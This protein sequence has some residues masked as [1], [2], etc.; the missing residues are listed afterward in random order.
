MIISSSARVQPYPLRLDLVNG[1]LATY[2]VPKTLCEVAKRVARAVLIPF[3][4]I[5]DLA[6]NSVR[7]VGNFCHN[8][9]CCKKKAAPLPPDVLIKALNNLPPPKTLPPCTAEQEALIEELITIM[10]E[11]PPSNFYAV[12]YL[13]GRKDRL[14][15]IGKGI[16][17]VYPLTLLCL[18]SATPQRKKKVQDIFNGWLS[19][20]E[21]MNYDN[22]GGSLT[23]VLNG[24]ADKNGLTMYVEDFAN[25]TKMSREKV[26]EFFH[27][28]D[29]EGLVAHLIQ[30]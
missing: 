25:K 13:W 26:L 1:L 11:C 10:S 29:W 8:L 14:K 4:F 2:P 3:A 6:I 12:P 16:Q 17:S 18:G 23:A 15:A 28:R 5:V 9:G 22:G 27:S 24:E 19:R 21:F 7:V 20:Y 30:Q